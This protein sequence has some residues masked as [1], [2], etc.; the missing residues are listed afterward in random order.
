[1]NRLLTSSTTVL[2]PPIIQLSFALAFSTA[3]LYMTW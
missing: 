2:M 3:S 1:M